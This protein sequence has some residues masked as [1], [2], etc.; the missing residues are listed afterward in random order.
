V[1]FVLLAILAAPL[2]LML[3]MAFRDLLIDERS[4]PGLKPLASF[5]VSAQPASLSIDQAALPGR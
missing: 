4:E 1:G 2:P 5:E 3:A